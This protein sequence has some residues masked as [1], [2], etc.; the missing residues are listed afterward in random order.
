MGARAYD[1]IRTCTFKASEVAV[2]I[3][4]ERG[5]GSSYYLKGYC[6][7]LNVPFFSVDIEPQPAFAIQSDGTA[8]LK[9]MRAPI[10]FAYLDNFDYIFPEIEGKSWVQDQISH[11]KTLGYEMNNENSITAH[12]DQAVEVARLSVPGT[13][14]VLDDT[15]Q[16]NGGFYGKGAKAVPFLLNQ[17]WKL[18]KTEGK[19]FKSFTALR[20]ER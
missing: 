18:F 12:L 16:E 13:L 4:A 15:W 17:G 19:T 6:D 1:L 3:G 14:V 7:A 20:R 5:E 10:K 9:Q 8:Y 2:E 11:Y